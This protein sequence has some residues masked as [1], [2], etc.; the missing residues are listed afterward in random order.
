MTAKVILTDFAHLITLLSH[1]HTQMQE[2]SDAIEEIATFY[3]SQSQ[4]YKN[5]DTLQ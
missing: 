5:Q 2:K 3:W 4:L 1:T